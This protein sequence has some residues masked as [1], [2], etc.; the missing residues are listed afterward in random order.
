M[1]RQ[2]RVSGSWVQRNQVYLGLHVLEQ[3]AH[4]VRLVGAVVF[5]LDQSPLE[6]DPPVHGHRVAA[7]G[8]HECVERP[9]A[10][11]RHQ[12]GALGLRCAVQRHGQAHLAFLIS[13]P[14]DAGDHADGGQGDFFRAQT[15][16]GAIAEDIHGFHDRV[17][18]MQRLAHAHQHDIAQPLMPVV[19]R[20]VRG[21]RQRRIFF[22]RV[23]QH[24]IHMHRLCD[25]L[26]GSEVPGVAH[27]ARRAKHAAHRATHLRADA[28]R[29]APGV[30]HEH[31]LDAMRII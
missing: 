28:R 18:V 7:A 27:L 25:D 5:S 23:T 31:G 11:S 12:C 30:A 26:A 15:H 22:H 16:A 20:R 6:K 3:R 13:H 1:T 29:G 10:R 4:R 21:F 2:T 8:F 19:R 24:T 17:I 9:R 14:M